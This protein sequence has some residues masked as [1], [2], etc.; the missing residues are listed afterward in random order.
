VSPDTGVVAG[1]GVGC[2]TSAGFFAAGMRKRESSIGVRR[3]HASLSRR[4][5]AAATEGDLHTFVRR[6]PESRDAV[7]VAVNRGKAPATLKM[8]VQA[9]WGEGDPEDAWNGGTVAR[10][11]NTIETTIA[12]LSA[13]ILTRAP[14][15]AGAAKS[16]QGRN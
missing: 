9:E 6:D 2:G 15:K 12:P 11:G 4:K 8:T 10:S 16:R 13:R 14:G 3:A 7:V 1:V 5:H